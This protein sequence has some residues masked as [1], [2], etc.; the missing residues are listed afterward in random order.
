[1]SIAATL[2]TFNIGKS[3]DASGKEIEPE[4]GWTTS[5]VMYVVIFFV[6]GGVRE[7]P[8]L[9]RTFHPV[10]RPSSLLCFIPY[11]HPTE[12]GATF[13]PRSDKAVELIKIA[14]EELET[15]I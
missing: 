5:L 14:L 12:Y 6:S 9:L 10:I 13:A 15:P 4:I 2:K 1:M 3:K 8:P 11:R 7:P